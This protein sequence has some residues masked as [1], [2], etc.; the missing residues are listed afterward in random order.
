MTVERGSK[1]IRKFARY[2]ASVVLAALLVVGSTAT[3]NA[4]TGPSAHTG[5]S[6]G[7]QRCTVDKVVPFEA[8]AKDGTVLRGHVYLPDGQRPYATV[9]NLSPYWNTVHEA[10]LHGNSGSEG[11]GRDDGTI[12]KN[13]DHLLA[14]CFA[15]A[16]VNMRGTGESDG[17]FQ[18]GSRTD[19][20]D[21]YTVVEALA[22]QPWS[23]GKIGMYGGSYHAWSQFAAMAR[24]PPHLEAAIPF[25]GVID[26]WSLLTR[27]GAPILGGPAVFPA[28]TARTSL[29][30]LE[31][32][33]SKHAQ[34]PA[35]MKQTRENTLELM[36]TGDRTEY[37]EKRDLRPFIYGT[38]IPVLLANGLKYG[39]VDG[40]AHIT[41]FE[42]LWRLL[43]PGRTRFVLG[44]W[45]HN[46][47]HN[48]RNDWQDMTVAWFDHYLRGGPQTV[49]PGVVEYQ[50]DNMEWHTTNRWPP[51]ANRKQLYIS[52]GRLV[53][54]QSRVEDSQTRFQSADVDTGS[55]CGPHQA[56]YVSPK[57]ANDVRI[58]GNFSMSV[59][60]EANLPGGNFVGVLM[61][62][63]SDATSCTELLEN[64][65]ESGHLE[66]DLRHWE[67]SGNST[68]F[69]T[70]R[71]TEVSGKSLPLATVVPAGH[72]LVLVL[73]AHARELT[74]EHLKPTITIHTGNEFP[75]SITLPIADGK[76]RFLP[77]ERQGATR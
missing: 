54:Q 41:Q 7:T 23:S 45:P 74:P 77:D 33:L 39:I 28:W 12:D 37:W 43:K 8:S 20:D 30:V 51:R 42:G 49:K 47:P 14:A 72:R 76:L 4:G 35:L 62:S 44:Q 48:Y 10:A 9:L 73:G 6:T 59:P 13:Y 2:G 60:V 66:M 27:R 46:W 32:E 55:T 17:C 61:H 1:K 22:K 64:A 69:P 68:N 3:G 18:F 25:S 26:P 56:M 5:T 34:C 52:D 16:A 70:G 11:L 63:P 65:E 15:F 21:A 53:S 67:D 57:L 40:E 38:K 31:P 29:G 71:P 24:K 36:A 19:W 75:G 50:D 58:A